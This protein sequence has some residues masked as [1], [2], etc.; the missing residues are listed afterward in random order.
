[1]AKETATP[2]RFSDYLMKKILE[3]PKSQKE[4]AAAA[5]FKSQNMITML[6]LGH[7]KLALDRVPT[8][9]KVLNTDPVDMFKLALTQFYDDASVR[10]LIDLLEAGIS[11]EER[12]ILRIIRDAAGAETPTVTPER[13]VALREAFASTS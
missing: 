8:M 6:K 3:S 9:A 11:P 10:L 2:T 5:G 13:E 7:V 4:I 1:M 12:K